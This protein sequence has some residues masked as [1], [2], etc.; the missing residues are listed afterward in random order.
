MGG[1]LAQS[2]DGLRR[3]S[4]S[5]ATKGIGTAVDAKEWKANAK[6]LGPE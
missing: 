5:L 2:R 3:S 4:F 6:A 1:A